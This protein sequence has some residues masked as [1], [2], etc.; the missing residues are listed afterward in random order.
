MTTEES[1]KPAEIKNKKRFAGFP[2]SRDYK[3]DG[4]LFLNSNFES[5]RV[6]KHKSSREVQLDNFSKVLLKKRLDSTPD[7]LTCSN[8]VPRGKFLKAKLASTSRFLGSPGSDL[9]KSSILRRHESKILKVNQEDVSSKAIDDP[10]QHLTSLTAEQR[11]KSG[12]HSSPCVSCRDVK[13]NEK[14]TA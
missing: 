5:L 10:L 8:P 1:D 14:V 2:V 9:A 12:E 6:C 7:F 3:F 13:V 11:N 4:F